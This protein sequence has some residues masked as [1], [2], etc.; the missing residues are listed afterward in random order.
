M[1]ILMVW[2]WGSRRLRRSSFV[3]RREE[4]GGLRTEVK[5]KTVD[6]ACVAIRSEIDGLG[7]GGGL[8]LQAVLCV[9][10]QD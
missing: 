8:E 9:Y 4:G 6:G 1:L 7:L 2:V 10:P 3:V 5:A